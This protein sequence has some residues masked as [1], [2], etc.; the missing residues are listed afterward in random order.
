[1]TDRKHLSTPTRRALWEAHGRKCAYTGEIVDWS[2]LEI[3]HIIPL[4]GDEDNIKELRSKGIINSGFDF[5]GFEN[6]LPTSSLRNKQKTNFTFNNDSIVFYLNIAAQKKEGA[7]SLY[8]TF[9]NSDNALRGYLQI[10]SQAEKNDI[11]VDDLIGYLQ[12]QSDGEVPLRLCLEIDGD[13]ISSANSQYAAILM[14]KP[15]ALSRGSIDHVLLRN[16]NG[17]ETICTTANQ[18]LAAKAA[19]LQPVTQF[20]ITSYGFADE[21][22]ELLRAVKE[23]R[24]APISE[25]RLPHVTLKNLDRWAAVWASDCFVDTQIDLSKYKSILSLVDAELLEVEDKSVW[26]L[27]AHPNPN[28]GGLSIQ[29]RELMRADLDRDGREE[30]LVS[31]LIFARQGTLR[32]PSVCGAKMNPEGLLEPFHLSEPTANN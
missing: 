25:I 6:L 11:G 28:V 7:E 4:N 3:D 21:T 9:V 20:D 16:D 23:S 30:I 19:G 29:L 8:K 1:M 17:E 12:H 26:V 27:T 18:F 10:K 2:E 31:S 14:D 13:R 22:S 5:N 32:A 24:Y 15:F